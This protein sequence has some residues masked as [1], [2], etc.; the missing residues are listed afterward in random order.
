ML[1]TLGLSFMVADLCLMVWGGDPISVAHA[2]D[3]RRRDASRSASPFPTYRLS[4]ILIAV[5]IAA[6]LWGCSTR[7]GSAR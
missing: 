7:R 3:R 4:I 2:G 1:V 5:V 6:A